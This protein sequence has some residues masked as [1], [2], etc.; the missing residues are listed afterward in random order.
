MGE[1]LTFDHLNKELEIAER[2]SRQKERLLKQ[3]MFA[4]GVKSLSFSASASASPPLIATH[5]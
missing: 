2:L 5:A 1:V 4:R 3:L